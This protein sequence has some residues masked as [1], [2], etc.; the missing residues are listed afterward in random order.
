MLPFSEEFQHYC[1]ELETTSAWG[2]QLEVRALSMA[3]GKP[4][5]VIQ[6]EGPSII[7]GEECPTTPL[8][9]S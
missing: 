8:I 4:I 1:L 2:G 5:E 3:L 7:M 6:A 9:L